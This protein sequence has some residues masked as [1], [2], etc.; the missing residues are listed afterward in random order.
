MEIDTPFLSIVIPAYNEELRILPTLE[1]IAEY[2]GKQEY[3]AEVLVVDDGSRD[4]TSGVVMDFAG[5]HQVVKLVRNPH[6]GK[7][8]AVK[9]GMLAAT[10]SY[11]FL[12]DADLSMP[13][14]ELQKFLPPKLNG[15]NV[16]IGSRELQGAHRYD[17][18][19]YRHLMGRIFNMLVQM[20]AVRGIKDTQCGFKCFTSES[21]ETLFPLQTMDGFGFDVEIL[22]IAQK[23][24]YKVVEIPIEWYHVAN[25]KISPFS[26]TLRMVREALA[27]RWN[28]WQRKYDK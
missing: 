2:L 15:Y 28:D 14:E 6:R 11:R 19:G 10:G 23:R 8:Y 26:D 12:C 13:I 17:E 7:G 20:V 9:T 16:A 3:S 5:N 4:N 1:K 21:A 18:P 24:K 27:V 25:S 22:F